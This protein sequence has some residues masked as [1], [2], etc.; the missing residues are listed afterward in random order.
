MH[1]RT[2]RTRLAPGIWALSLLLVATL[3]SANDRGVPL[4]QVFTPDDYAAHSQNWSVL[5]GADGLIY[6]GNGSGVLQYDGAR[7]KLYRT[8]HNTRVRRVIDGTTGHMLAATTDDLFEVEVDNTPDLNLQMHSLAQDWPAA[9]QSFGEAMGLA[10]TSAGIFLQASHRVL[11]LQA[12]GGLRQWDSAAGFQQSFAIADTWYVL[13]RGRGLLRFEADAIAASELPLAPDG[14]RLS[15]DQ[16]SFMLQRRDG[17]IIVASRTLGLLRYR[18]NRLR[19]WA[20][21]IDDWIRDQIVVPG[22]E[23]GDGSLVLGSLRAGLARIDREGR[24]MQFLDERDGLPSNSVYALATDNQGGLWAGLDGG[25]ARIAWPGP[26]TRFDRRQ[27]VGTVWGIGRHRGRLVLATRLGLLLGKEAEPGRP[28]QFERAPGQPTQAWETLSVDDALWIAGSDGVWRIRHTAAPVSHWLAERIHAE[29]FAYSLLRDATAADAVI[30]A[31]AQGLVRITGIHDAQPTATLV[32]GYTGESR[33][34]AQ[35]RAGIVWAG[36]PNGRL[37]R[38]PRGADR[39]DVLG[40]FERLP[41]GMTWPANVDGN[42]LLGA[43]DGLY[44]WNGQHM[45]APAAPSLDALAYGESVNRLAQTSASAVWIARANEV[46]LA[47][48]GIDGDWTL[49]ADPLRGIAQAAVYAFFA[50]T[51]GSVWIGRERD[52]VRVDAAIPMPNLPSVPPRLRGA[53]AIGDQ[54]FVPLDIS[55]NAAQWSAG[56]EHLRLLFARPLFGLTQATRFQSHLEGVDSSR[57]SS[58]WEAQRDYTNLSGGSYRFRLTTEVPQPA[59]IA[60]QTAWFEFRIAK[61]WYRNAW[62]M[63]LWS[64]MVAGL[65][66]L[67]GLAIAGWRSRVLIARNRALALQVLEQTRDLRLQTEQLQA[68]D[69]AKTRFFAGVAHD[70]RSPLILIL[71]PLQELLRGVFGPV[72][73]VAADQLRRVESNAR[74]LNR[75]V[76]SLLDLHQI[77]AGRRALRPQ[78]QDVRQFVEGVLAHFAGW[79]EEHDVVLDLDS[80]GLRGKACFDSQAMEQV[81]F[82]VLGNA[83]KFLPEAGRIDVVLSGGGD[84]ELS[85]RVRDNGPGFAPEL[86]AQVFD[87]YVRGEQIPGR[88]SKGTGLGL[89]LCRELIQAHSGRIAARNAD[90]G[91]AEIEID[92]PPTRASAALVTAMDAQEALPMAAPPEPLSPLPDEIESVDRTTVLLVDDNDEL[93][94]FL[95]ERLRADYRVLEAGDGQ[96]ALAMA[97]TELP[98]VVVSDVHMPLLDGLELA[99]SLRRDAE[100]GTIPVLLMASHAALNERL[101]GLETGANDFLAKPF[102]VSELIA[103]IAALIAAQRQL[104]ARLLAT[105]MA[106]VAVAT[107]EPEFLRRVRAAI[108]ARLDDSRFGVSELAEALHMERSTL[109]KRLKALNAEAP[110][111]LMRNHRLDAAAQLLVQG[112]GQVTEVAYACGFES[113]SYFSRVFRERFG[114]TPREYAVRTR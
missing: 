54:G 53:Y 94:A 98:D 61:P 2:A 103:R 6:V 106:A 79:M 35:D 74:R 89:A 86:L 109:F 9:A 81:L 88:R 12:G 13:D 67:L 17:E 8:P 75:L 19:P 52:L 110:V 28:M 97:R 87:H 84:T 20:T 64:A 101:A 65:I 30:A 93:R 11:L 18:D 40:A 27:G 49:N 102:H 108:D 31:T 29:R 37:L 114:K 56:T 55:V 44:V 82:N 85:I 22:V 92:L 91:G 51:D 96:Q 111:Q 25:I 66:W 46:R 57:I 70:V 48:R 41:E 60:E 112:V 15:A 45:V 62:A 14:A 33:Q 21:E 76:E 107:T 104:R 69:Q 26:I 99:R 24:L 43:G 78:Q 59:P 23:L 63:L 4:L 42:L 1:G 10:R 113:L 32:L 39:V 47:Q 36:T 90:Q 72:P 58:H 5:Q 7:W 80:S 34:L 3:L 105:P 71:E 100:T 77:E 50:D 95:A 83:L 73:L 16:L 68:A 38:L